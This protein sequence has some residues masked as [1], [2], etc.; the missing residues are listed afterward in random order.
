MHA[1]EHRV[2]G[3]RPRHLGLLGALRGATVQ[4]GQRALQR[5]ELEDGVDKPSRCTGGRE[6]P[7]RLLAT[8]EALHQGAESKCLEANP[9]WAVKVAEINLPPF[10]ARRRQLVQGAELPSEEEV[11]RFGDPPVAL[12]IP[13]VAQFPRFP[14]VPPRLQLTRRPNRRQ[15]VAVDELLPRA[16]LLMAEEEAAPV[17]EDGQVRW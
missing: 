5:D 2:A 4:A 10:M 12:C 13:Q 8:G 1:L 16:F 7:S 11:R 15:L 9:F 3:V 17:R 6:L 14:S